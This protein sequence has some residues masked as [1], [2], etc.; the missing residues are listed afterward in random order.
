MTAARDQQ[1]LDKMDRLFGVYIEHVD[2]RFD[3]ILEYVQQIPEMK[4]GIGVLKSEMVEVKTE[5]RLM[6]L[7]LMENSRDIDQLKQLHPGMK[8]G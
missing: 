2:A 4:A 1:L 3:A 6:R 7:V 5:Q 8:H